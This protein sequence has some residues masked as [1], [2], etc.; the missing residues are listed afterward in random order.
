MKKAQ[1]SSEYSI[2]C[3]VFGLYEVPQCSHMIG[4]GGFA[5]AIE[6]ESFATNANNNNNTY[7]II[8]N[9]KNIYMYVEMI[10]LNGMRITIV[11]GTKCARIPTQRHTRLQPHSIIGIRKR[12]AE[13]IRIYLSPR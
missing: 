12:A 4:G 10:E 5:A 7:D 11:H 8:Y 13:Y 6:R 2:L 3:C 1:Y 9:E